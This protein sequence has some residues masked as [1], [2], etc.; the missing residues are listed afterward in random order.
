MLLQSD[1]ANAAEKQHL[2][3][4]VDNTPYCRILKT[5]GLSNDK[6]PCK[7][8]FLTLRMPWQRSEV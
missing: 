1:A 4:E 7:N 3:E 5:G 2:K 8:G 6:Y